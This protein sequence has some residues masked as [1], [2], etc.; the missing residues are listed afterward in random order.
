M[1]SYLWTYISVR[2]FIFL[3]SHL[4]NCLLG[5]MRAFAQIL[6]SHSSKHRPSKLL[7]SLNFRYHSLII[8]PNWAGSALRTSLSCPILL[9]ISLIS[10]PE[11]NNT[12]N[13][14]LWRFGLVVVSILATDQTQPLPTTWTI[15]TSSPTSSF[16]CLPPLLSLPWPNLSERIFAVAPPLQFHEAQLVKSRNRRILELLQVTTNGS[17]SVVHQGADFS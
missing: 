3:P 11:K 8:P 1:L 7:L 17:A 12:A 16:G 6:I 9:R 10:Q 4:S 2:L 14:G 5:S 15:Q 13:Q